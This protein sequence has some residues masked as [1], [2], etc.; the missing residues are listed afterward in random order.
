MTEKKFQKINAAH[1]EIRYW[2]DVL[3]NLK[4]IPTTDF[5]IR[6]STVGSGCDHSVSFIIKGDELIDLITK[7][8]QTAID[9]FERL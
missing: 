4:D 2:R 6:A 8:L 3:R 5:H 9:E 7:K 1:S